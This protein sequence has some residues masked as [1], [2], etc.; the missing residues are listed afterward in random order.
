[1]GWLIDPKD[2]SILLMMPDRVPELYQ[3]DDL[4]VFI[5]KIDLSLSANDV[6]NWLK[7]D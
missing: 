3:E 7:L 5:E 2:R 6:F 4:L 1:M